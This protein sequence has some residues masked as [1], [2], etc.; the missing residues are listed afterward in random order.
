MATENGYVKL[1]RSSLDKGWLS[2]PG[3]WTFWCY[4]LIK[5]SH[6]EHEQI[7][8]HQVVHLMPGQF[9]FGRQ[10]AAEE[11]ETTEQKVRTNLAFL[12]AQQNV[13]IKSTN[14]FSI[15]TV[16]N[17]DRYQVDDIGHQPSNQ[18]TVNQQ[19][20]TN[21]N[22]KNLDIN[23]S[24]DI[25]IVTAKKKTA[26]PINFTLTEDK[27]NYAIKKGLNGNCENTFEAFKN[28]HLARGSLFI[29]WDSAWRTW[30]LKAI[31]WDVNKSTNP[32]PEVSKWQKNIL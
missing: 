10:K 21:K 5:A 12:A 32:K 11:L 30:V 18:P 14:K 24:L 9:I 6:K 26:F 28:H 4:C 27:K 22:V 25:N 29:S 16:I 23:N 20:T 3:L 8:G 15:I 13:T 1:W 17:W 2:N 7:V 19:L 31:E